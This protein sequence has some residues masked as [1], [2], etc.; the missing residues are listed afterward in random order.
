[1]KNIEVFYTLDL[2]NLSSLPREKLIISAQL[3]TR[4]QKGNPVEPLN[5]P[6]NRKGSHEHTWGS[7]AN[8]LIS[9]SLKVA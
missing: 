7:L 9:L 4:S 3:R 8:T 6:M 2:K 5:L 1:M